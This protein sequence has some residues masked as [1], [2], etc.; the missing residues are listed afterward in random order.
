MEDFKTLPTDVLVNML[1]QCMMN[2]T[3]MRKEG[4]PGS[5]Y[6]YCQTTILLLQS[7]LLSRSNTTVPAYA[8]II[9]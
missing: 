4:S 8:A 5:E 7:E 1:A 3:R 9:L 2:E 6:I